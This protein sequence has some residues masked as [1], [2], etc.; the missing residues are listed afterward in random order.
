[1]LLKVRASIKKPNE[2]C[3]LTTAHS[4]DDERILH[5]MAISAEQ[6][7]YG[8]AVA[9]CADESSQYGN[10]PLI[11]ARK[12]RKRGLIPNR[13]TAWLSVT[14]WA[15]ASP[16]GVFQIH[17]PDLI[18]GGLILRMCGRKV[19]YDVHDDYQKN[20]ETRLPRLLYL[21]VLVALMWWI[22]EKTSSRFFNGIIVA[23]RHLEGKFRPLK[24]I[25]LGN[26]P[27]MD[28]TGESNTRGEKTFNL[29]YVGGVNWQRGIRVSLEALRLI[30]ND[31]IRF[32]IVGTC[33]DQALLEELQT[34]P[35]IILHGQIPWEKLSSFYEKAH[36]GLALYQ[37]L[38]CFIYCPGENAVK[39]LEYMA[40]G[41]PV[42]TSNF[43]GLSKFIGDGNFG[44]VVDPTDPAAIAKQISRLHQDTELRQ[45]LGRNGRQLFESDFNWEVH[46]PKL[47]NFYAIVVGGRN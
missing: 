42:V 28:F 27:N 16:F 26:F 1:M 2:I 37:P 31:E 18:P 5:R 21:N 25:V 38:P 8:G 7:G 22:F 6:M 41:I 4:L 23:D 40:A 12:K 15:L 3:Q 39:V 10:V 13:F 30:K 46:E 45:A 24:S 34:E 43:P 9:G 29:L 14:R 32:H 17:D 47:A 36:L 19:I 11:A 44:C 33:R 20:I 35:R